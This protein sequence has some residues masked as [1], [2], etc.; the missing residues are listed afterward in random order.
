MFHEGQ[1]DMYLFVE[2]GIRGGMSFIAHRH[3]KANNKYLKDFDSTQPSK[4]I[5]YLDANNLYGWAM[6]QKLAVGDYKWENVEQWNKERIM[7]ITDEDERGYIFEVDLEYPKDIHDKHNLY[8]LC[9]E[10]KRVKT[11]WL[12]KY[13]NEIKSKLKIND[14]HV[15]KLITDLT[16]KNNYILHYKNLQLCIQLGMKLN[17]IHK[18]LS[19]KSEAWL[20]DYITSNSML[21]QKAKADKDA[22]KTNIYKIKNN[23]VFGKQMENVRNRVDIKLMKDNGLTDDKNDQYLKLISQPRYKKR[24]I[25]NENLVAVHR[26]KKAI[27]LDKPIINGM[28]ILDL[29]KYLMY[30]FYYNVLQKRYGDKI[31]LLMTDTDSLVVEIETEDVY[32]DMGNMKEYYDFSEYPKELYEEYEPPKYMFDSD[33]YIEQRKPNLFFNKMIF[34]S[35]NQAVV[36][37]FKDEFASKIVTEFV[38]LRS[39]LYSLTIQG[40]NKEK[41]VCKGCKKCVINKELKFSDFKNT[42]INKTKLNKDMNFIKS[43]LHNVNTVNVNKN[44]ISCFDNKRYILDDGITSF[45][46]GHYKI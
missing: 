43:K 46:F 30:D 8:P 15:D 40:E 4:Y 9:P 31:K 38:G 11:E 1:S 26:H 16:N 29:S 2:K 23:S 14:D 36:G 6:N 20:K 7:N 25:I 27:K 44:V 45:S 12:S 39:K 33:E 42:L 22:F 41:K 13:Q 10:R 3:S 21:R 34:N 37:K 18:C 24:T 17:K 19:Y 28:I 5:L 35:E 32:E